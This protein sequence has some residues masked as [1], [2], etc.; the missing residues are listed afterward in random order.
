[1]PSYWLKIEV[2]IEVEI[3]ISNSKNH[4]ITKHDKSQK[5][6]IKLELKR[7]ISVEGYSTPVYF[8]LTA[9]SFARLLCSHLISHPNESISFQND[10]G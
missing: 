5:M 8:V 3:I 4:A 6:I 2:K 7:S 9:F 1:M 10:F